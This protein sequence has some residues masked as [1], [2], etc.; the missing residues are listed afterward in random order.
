MSGVGSVYGQALYD[1]TKEEGTSETVM[2]QLAV[3]DEAF[4]GSPEFIRLLCAAN[5]S[6]EERCVVL[7]DSFRGKLDPNLLNFLKLLTEHG[8]MRHF[9]KCRQTFVSVY[10]EEH[11]ILEVTAITAVALTTQ[12]SD[13]LAQKL[14]ALTNKKITLTNRVDPAC[15]GGVRLDYDGK[16]VDGTLRHRLEDIRTLLANT[17]L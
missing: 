10:N 17:V 1:L 11:G 15:L 8:Y 3:L 6:K 16:R 7:D 13:R 2:Q 14:S 9:S 5:I 12:Q 4:R